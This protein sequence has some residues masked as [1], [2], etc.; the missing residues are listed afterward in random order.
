MLTFSMQKNARVYKKCFFSKKVWEIID[1]SQKMLKEKKI[2]ETFTN[3]GFHSKT[4]D[5]RTVTL[6]KKIQ[7]QL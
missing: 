6:I 1:L 5:W 3:V 7:S 2:S 4:Q